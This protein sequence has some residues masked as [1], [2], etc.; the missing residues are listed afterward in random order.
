MGRKPGEQIVHMSAKLTLIEELF[1]E[2]AIRLESK[3]LKSASKNLTKWKKG[4]PI[5]ENS[6]KIISEV[7]NEILQRKHCIEDTYF[8]ERDLDEQK[9]NIFF[10]KIINNRNRCNPR[11]VLD[12][13]PCYQIYKGY[14]KCWISW[15]LP[16]ENKTGI[17]QFLI[18]IGTDIN[19]KDVYI[20]DKDR[21]I[22]LRANSINCYMS[23]RKHWN[24]HLKNNGTIENYIWWQGEMLHFPSSDSLWFCFW[25]LSQKTAGKFANIN[26]NAVN[27]SDAIDKNGIEGLYL[28][29]PRGMNG[30]SLPPV[31]TKILLQRI[32]NSALPTDKLIMLLNDMGYKEEHDIERKICD[33]LKNGL[34]KCLTT[35]G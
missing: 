3:G 33:K 2:F 20:I 19:D 27:D 10:D 34:L 28:A 29:Q 24:A 7:I 26:A 13:S 6:K 9:L 16:D 15:I 22:N 30:K 32:E 14:Y 35:P 8:S 12:V 4:D 5:N 23:T 21:S 11:Y 18:K 31:C 25:N 17:Y 1:D